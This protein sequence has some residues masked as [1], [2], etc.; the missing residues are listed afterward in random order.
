MANESANPLRP[1]RFRLATAAPVV[2]KPQFVLEKAYAL[3]VLLAG[4]AP[5][6][7]LRESLVF[8]GS[9]CLRKA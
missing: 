7:A 4:I 9:T 8:K 1:L 2:G 3:S 6:P 5:V